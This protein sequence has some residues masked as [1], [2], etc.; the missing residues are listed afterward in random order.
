MYSLKKGFDSVSG[1]EFVVYNQSQVKIREI[2]IGNNS[3]YKK[4]LIQSLII[5]Y[6]QKTLMHAIM[7]LKL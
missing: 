5:F 6:S 4:R 2:V 7:K 3:I 1:L